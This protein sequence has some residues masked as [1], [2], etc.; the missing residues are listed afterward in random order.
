M[1][2]NVKNRMNRDD[3][4]LRA[5]CTV[6]TAALMAGCAAHLIG[7]AMGFALSWLEVYLTAAAAAAVVQA[8]RRGVAWTIGAA[9]ALALALGALLAVFLPE[10]TAALRGLMASEAE[11]AANYA[12]AGQGLALILALLLGALFAGLLYAPSSAPLALLVLLASVVCALAVNEDISLWMALPG[13]AAGVVAFGLPSDARREGVRPALLLPGALLVAL[14]L[15]LTPAA[16][17]TWEPLEELAEHIRAVVDDYVRFTEERVAFSINEK[18]YDRAGMID[19][20]VVAML[21]GAANPSE[22]AVM[23]VETD[24]EL[25]LRGTIKR[26]YTGYSWVD[27]SAKA[28]YLYYDFTH[29]GVRDDVFDADTTADS[30]A[31]EVR[32]AVVEML[33]AGTST[34][35][36]PAQLEQFDMGLADAVYYN[37]TGEIFLTR[38]VA[39]GDRYEIVARVPGSED[40]LVAETARRESVQDERYAAARADYTALPEGIDSRVYALA[41]ELT[42]GTNN[43]AEKAFA[44]QN[45]LAQNYH[46]TLDGG[47]PAP[48]QDFVSW[49]LLEAGE[50]YCSYYASAM[51]VLCRVAGLPA[52]YVEGYYVPAQGGGET[53][54]TGRNAHAWVEVYLNGLGWVAFDPT[55]RA[56]EA[57]GGSDRG[58]LDGSG[59][60]PEQG[61]TEAEGEETPFEN[62]D[63]ANDPGDAPTP[64]P[65]VAPEDSP[66][67]DPDGDGLDNPDDT[68]TPS[69]APDGGLNRPDDTPTPEPDGAPD[70][71]NPPPDAQSD[72]P[73]DEDARSHAWL[74]ILLAVLALLALIALAALWL[75]RRLAQTDPLKLCAAAGSAQMAAMILYRSMLTLLNQLGQ[76]PSSGETPEAFARRVTASIPNPAYERFVSGVARSRY[77][78]RPVS[79]ELVNAGREAYVVFLN[80]MRR[81]EK[82]RFHIRRALRGL[83]SFERI[84]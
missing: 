40:A 70:S 83:G 57:H 59:T 48:G 60:P 28:R 44:I 14:A 38:D 53:V 23:R 20:S 41:V 3:R 7:R 74:W 80:G 73:E 29:R 63:I 50:G 16:R 35:F 13:L 19:D 76:A 32:S 58:A 56:V 65:D 36:V 54:V 10:F 34:L 55:Q 22:D 52:R 82:L 2:N 68:P 5:V 8:G 78:G 17:I 81:G 11:L 67:P 75:R 37:S 27:D 18:G 46:Y 66:T 15:L 84:P 25:L 1:W 62:D 31:F 30:A 39:P 6:L 61:S 42:Q 71:P 49:F 4:L 12:G 26:S 77:S 43:A 72:S 9:A 64:T 79:R 47:T 24:G 21:G 69:P 45:Y 51:A 33:E